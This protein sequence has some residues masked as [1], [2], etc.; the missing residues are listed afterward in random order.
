[1]RVGRGEEAQKKLLYM[2]QNMIIFFSH[3]T[4]GRVRYGVEKKKVSTRRSVS[5]EVV[6]KT[7]SRTRKACT[8]VVV[9]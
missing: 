3:V 4:R 2:K 9:V 6:A 7:Q 8:A 5:W 1:M